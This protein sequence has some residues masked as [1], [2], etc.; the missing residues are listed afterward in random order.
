MKNFISYIERLINSFIAIL[1]EPV[2]VGKDFMESH[3]YLLG[4]GFIIIETVLSGLM[5][6]VAGFRLNI[7]V[8]GF[9]VIF[10]EISIVH[11]PV[12]T[13]FLIGMLLY[14]IDAGLLIVLIT[15]FSKFFANDLVDIKSAV[16]LTSLQAIFQIPV[17][18]VGIFISF[19][20]SLVGLFVYA[21]GKLLGLIIVSKI[22]PYEYK[23]KVEKSSYIVFSIYAAEILAKCL[24]DIGFLAGLLH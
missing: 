13:Y 16:V 12:S 22:Y 8:N 24:I 20:S 11:N 18:A 10:S 5:F 21:M 2:D 17:T 15:L 4:L 14:L 23:G 19:G 7:A 1:K 3:D 9:F 6:L